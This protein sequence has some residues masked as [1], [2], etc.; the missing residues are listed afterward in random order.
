MAVTALIIH[1]MDPLG[2]KIGG[3]ETF[4]R[5]FIKHAPDD[6]GIEFVGTT[7][8]R[9]A[10]PVGQWR[11][12]TVEGRQVSALPVT[13]VADENRKPRIPISARFA[14]GLRR[15]RNRIPRDGRVFTY[16]RIEPALGVLGGRNILFIHNSML[17]QVAGPSTEAAWRRAP[18]LYFALE[19]RLMHRMDRVFAV[20]EAM[21]ALYRSRYAA[22][23]DRFAFLPTWVD[24]DV[25]RP[26]PG[27]ASQARAEL[28]AGQRWPAD[29]RVLLF[30]GRLEAQKDPLRLLDAFVRIRAR[31][32]RARLAVVGAGSL[33][34]T[35]DAAVAA[36]GLGGEVALLGALNRDR[37][38]AMLQGADVFL[39]TSAF[40]G[41][42]ISVLEALACGLP[43]VAPDV[44]EVGR[45]VLDGQSGRLCRDRQPET[46]AEAALDLLRCPGGTCSEECVQAIAP[47]TATKVLAGLYDAIR[48]VGASVGGDAS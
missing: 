36:E 3:V 47:Y 1:Q 18:R 45:V 9:D 2:A 41:M 10:R 27:R 46:I 4:I 7:C 34:S 38:V 12:L 11:N 22:I 24:Q 31:E 5:A 25:F 20:T 26:Q 32:P 40:E 8:D 6:M 39:L 28:R 21:V 19:R 30:V 16:H 37:V 43:V 29:V 14:W 44:G 23:E 17:E 33:R 48:D 13:F 42:P 15:Y 35:L